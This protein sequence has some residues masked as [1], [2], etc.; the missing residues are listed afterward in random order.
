MAYEVFGNPITDETLKALPQYEGKTIT[1]HDRAYMA[2]QMKN[3]EEKD[4]N[5]RKY[6]E[7]LKSQYGNGV[8]TLCLIYNATGDP[9]HQVGSND[10][11]GHIASSPYPSVIANGQWGAFLHVHPT[12]AAAGS[13]AA[14]VYRGMNSN[15]TNYDWCI[16][17]V[18]PWNRA[19]NNHAYVEIREVGHFHGEGIWWTVQRKSE[20]SGYN[21][22]E[23][24]DGCLCDVSMGNETSPI[25]Q[26]IL[27]HD[28]LM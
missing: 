14:V 27:T 18:T 3:A 11:H 16:V 22:R 7:T 25:Y 17:W 5:A 12:G 15:G 24:M 10:W 20:D 26:A 4:V 13:Q 8:S 23:T 1:R 9:I 28:D 21:H 2:L 6:V 19:Y